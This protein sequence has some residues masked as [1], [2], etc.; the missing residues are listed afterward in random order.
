MCTGIYVQQSIELNIVLHHL[1]DV[2]LNLK[3][4]RSYHWSS[5][6]RL[7]LSDQ[8]FRHRGTLYKLPWLVMELLLPPFSNYNLLDILH[9]EI[10]WRCELSVASLYLWIEFNQ[11]V[12]LTTRNELVEKKFENSQI[13]T[14]WITKQNKERRNFK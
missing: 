13:Q 9:F 8:R 7:C 14:E 10:W 12:L 2:G 3:V 11:F 5:N 4:I 6:A 1:D